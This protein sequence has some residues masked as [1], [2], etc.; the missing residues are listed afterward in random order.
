MCEFFV[1]ARDPCQVTSPSTSLS[2]TQ[3][4]CMGLTL[5]DKTSWLANHSDP[6]AS[7]PSTRIELL[8]WAFY[9]GTRDLSSGL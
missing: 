5:P 4:M 3:L 7:L 9:S 2:D 8:C 1:K 6:P